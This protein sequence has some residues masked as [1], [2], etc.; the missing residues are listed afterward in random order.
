MLRV[1]DMPAHSAFGTK[2]LKTA[3]DPKTQSNQKVASVL[4]VDVAPVELTVGG[5]VVSFICL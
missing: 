1:H 4:F 3:Q 5:H 2:R